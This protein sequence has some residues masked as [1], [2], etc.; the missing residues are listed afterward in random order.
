MCD[1]RREGGGFRIIQ[2]TEDTAWRTGWLCADEGDQSRMR[3]QRISERLALTNG[4]ACC[5]DY[6]KGA[7]W[8]LAM[9][10]ERREPSSRIKGY[11]VVY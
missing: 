7:C 2:L 1:K 6:D 9:S 10:D 8:C 3:S 11:S 5:T 4:T